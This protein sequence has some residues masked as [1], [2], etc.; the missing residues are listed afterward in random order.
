MSLNTS[1]METV[2]P[3]EK[4]RIEDSI[5]KAEINDDLE[6]GI[7]D[8]A[9]GED[10]ASTGEIISYAMGS[11][12]GAFS[13]ATIVV[14]P[15]ILMLVLKVN[16][17]LVGLV[18]AL[19][20]IWDAVTDPVMATVTDNFRSRWGRRRP[21]VLIGGLVLPMILIAGW[22]LMPKNDKIEPNTRLIPVSSLSEKRLAEFGQLLVAYDVGNV[23]LQASDI[24][25]NQALP[26][27]INGDGKH[28][29]GLIEKA[30][31]KINSPIVTFV[32]E[33]SAA[34]DEEVTET[35]LLSLQPSV[36]GLKAPVAAYDEL[37]EAVQKIGAAMYENQEPATGDQKTEEDKKEDG[38]F[39][40]YDMR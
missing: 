8:P 37:G 21:F 9:A 18:T 25:G 31:K 36:S 3:I 27:T 12:A 40:I 5:E 15:L 19:K 13:N 24:T 39:S 11:L 10:D 33:D 23:R 6:Q 7:P 16:P 1:D 20:V 22:A 34:G 30:V 2:D 35:P 26:E 29:S 32:K 17:I 14:M 38:D 28:Q 4:K